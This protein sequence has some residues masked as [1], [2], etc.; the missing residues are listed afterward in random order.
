MENEVATIAEILARQQISDVLHCYCRAT[1]RLDVELFRTTFWED[2]GF[3]GGPADGPA[4]EII[5]YLFQTLM[6][7]MWELSQHTISNILIEF[8]GERAFVECY[9]NA[10]HLSHPTHESRA[11]LMGE[12][13]ALKAGFKPDDVIE[14]IFGG[15]YI[16]VFE[17]RNGEWRIL[18]RKIV[19]SFN[20][21][22]VYTGVREGGQFDLLKLRSARNR[23]D[24]VY[25]R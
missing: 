1:D 17:R 6:P 13:N 9:L 8:E 3:D 12:Q 7:D 11:A 21:V 15:R 16:D 19:P 4:L 14:F 10:F 24:P 18:K 20:Q 23:N 22:Q 25:K 5:P 2:G